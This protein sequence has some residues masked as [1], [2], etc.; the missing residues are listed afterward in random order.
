MKARV[1]ASGGVFVPPNQY[2]VMMQSGGKPKKAATRTAPHQV[3]EYSAK[4]QYKQSF[5]E[6][7]PETDQLVSQILNPEDCNDIVRWPNTYG[8][9]AVYKS[10]TVLNAKFSS[11][12]RCC[13]AVNPC[14]RNSIFTTFGGITAQ[15]LQASTTTGVANPN[16]Y[17]VQR[18][19]MAT[20]DL[21]EHGNPIIMA[22]RH[23][24][25]ACPNAAN[26]KMLYPVNITWQSTSTPRLSFRFPAAVAGQIQVTVLFYD[27][28]FNVVNSQS[29]WIG[30]V[31]APSGVGA[32]VAFAT[33]AVAPNVQY[34][35]VSYVT[36][37]LPYVGRS[38]IF[39]HDD[40][41]TPATMTAPNHA[42][43][44]YIADIKDADQ[45]EKSSGQAFVLA[46]SL[47]VTPEMSD[48]SNG[49]ML[50]IARIPANTMVGAEDQTINFSNWY[51][52]I[53]SLPNNAHDGPIK[54]GGYAFYVPQDETGYFYRDADSF[55][56]KDLPYVV[57]EFTVSDTTEA[58]I[59]RIKVCT[60]VQFTTSSS[61][62]ALCPSSRMSDVDF[63]HHVMSV[64]PAAYNNR[65]HKDGIK[66]ALKTVGKSAVKIL[67]NPKTY[68]T[69][70]TLAALLL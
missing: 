39:I 33:L 22:S 6:V 44:C 15:G 12:G 46:Q 4:K 61:V 27:A 67:K 32:D 16:P 41:A 45:I 11:T 28:G 13:V 20:N 9:S 7:S 43:H 30:N 40:N 37:A 10:K 54:E 49:G 36:L 48:L 62:Y 52:W 21:Q 14:L 70:A 60:I 35:S 29:A 69:A 68:T 66:A 63:V 5:K 1:E 42:Q 2:K 47:L 55:L 26:N 53:A 24:L 50:S 23:A 51:D 57:S 19:D 18:L 59:V 38:Y 17:S 3:A 56:F 25:L 34:F 64:V 65:D 58:A 8:L 31:T